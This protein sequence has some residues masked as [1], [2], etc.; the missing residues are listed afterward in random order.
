MDFLRECVGEEGVGGGGP[1]V[2]DA[3]ARGV[4]GREVVLVESSSSENEA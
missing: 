1:G 2:S 4:E 3:R